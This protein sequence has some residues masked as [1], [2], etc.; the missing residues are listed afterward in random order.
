MEQQQVWIINNDYRKLDEFFTLSD[1]KRLF[2]VC[3]HFMRNMNIGV[4][5]ESLEKRLGIKVTRFSEFTPNPLYDSVVKGVRSFREADCDMIAAV[6]GGS[7]MDVAKCIK[8]YVNM[9]PARSYLS[10][11]IIPNKIKF[12]AIP[13]TA[14]TGSEATRFAVIYENG[15]KQSISDGSCIPSFVVMDPSALETLPEYHRKSS[16][17]DAFCHAIEAFWS[18]RSTKE[19][20][21]YSLEAIRIILKYKDSYLANKRQGNQ[22]MLQGA[23]IA[24][25][26]INIAQTTAGHAMCYKL[27]GLYGVAHGH[28]AALCV[29][30]LWPYMAAHPEKCRDPRGKDYL[31]NMF[32]ELAAAMECSG[33]DAAVNMFTGILDELGFAMSLQGDGKDIKVLKTSVNPVRLGNTPVLPGTEDIERI[34]RQILGVYEEEGE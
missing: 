29:A 28:A 7:A 12:M 33:T 13:T 32:S 34:Y 4:Y 16:M 30:R 9:D 11:K 27:T 19:S 5:F 15:K 24:G 1:I 22:K 2:L 8:L 6:G 21:S 31:K 3:G 25:K 20:Q 23:H 10:Q 18:I 26:A 17:M 14:G